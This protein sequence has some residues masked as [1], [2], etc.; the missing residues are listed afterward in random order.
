MDNRGNV[1]SPSVLAAVN[2]HDTCLLPQAV[3][4]LVSLAY[5]LNIDI[6]GSFVTFDPAFYSKRNQQ[7]IEAAHMIPVIKPNHR[8]TKDQNIIA[9]REAVFAGVRPIY[10]LRFTSERNF[11]WEDKYR[12]VVVRYEK[13]QTN[14]QGWRDLAAA[15]VNF[16]WCFGRT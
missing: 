4:G 2:I 13:K 10:R 14:A 5:D 6:H 9:Q 1:L 3:Q 7:V 15:M 12:R 8:N 11:A 16:R